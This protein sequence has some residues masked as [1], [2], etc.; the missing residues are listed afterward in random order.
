MVISIISIII[1]I[2]VVRV[3][4]QRAVQEQRK[5]EEEKNIMIHIL[6][7]VQYGAKYT[8]A[9]AVRTI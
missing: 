8:I 2:T 4:K 5:E 6:I 3:C 9:H 1:V 7:L